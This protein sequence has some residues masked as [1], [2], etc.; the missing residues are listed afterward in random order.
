MAGQSGLTS[1]HVQNMFTAELSVVNSL[2]W[3]SC[4]FSQSRKIV[5]LDRICVGQKEFFGH[6]RE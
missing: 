1:D 5:S 2:S 3:N 6:K 4:F